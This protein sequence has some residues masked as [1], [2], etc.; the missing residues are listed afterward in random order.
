VATSATLP[1]RGATRAPF[2]LPRDPASLGSTEAP[3]SPLAF[4][5]FIVVNAVLL[6]RPAEIVPS[7]Q[8]LEL[9]F[10]TIAFCGVLAAGDVLRYFSGRSLDTQPITL[11]VAGLFIAV[12]VPHLITFNVVEGWKTGFH[13][14]KQGVYFILL[15]SLVNTPG[16]LR[17]F[18]RCLL[19]ICAVTVVV[20]VLDYHD[21]VKVQNLQTAHETERSNW[22]DYTELERLQFTG[23][24]N[25]PNEVCVWLATLL[26]LALWCL[27]SDRDFLRRALWLALVLL[28][29]YGIFLTRSRGGFL[30]MVA[31]LGVTVWLRYGR[32][33][34]A[35]LA[36]IGLPLLLVLFAGRQTSLDA[37][38][39]TG[40]TRVQLWSDWLD[41][42]RDSPLVGEGMTFK[43]DLPPE[44]IKELRAAGMFMDHVAHNSYLQ[45]FADVG[46][47]GGSLFLGACGVALWSI[48]RVG[49]HRAEGLD[50][51]ARGVQPFL[52]G[53][54][55]AY[56]AG[57]MTL[58]LWTV[59]PTYIV[60]ALAAAYPHLA[61][62]RPALPPVRFDVNLL[63]RFAVAG[64]AFLAMIYLVVRL[65]VNWG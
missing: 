63:G 24:L 55:T 11:C 13:F 8:G 39:G 9:Y 46:F 57:M 65:F 49:R 61:R 3:S 62:G 33:K 7:L 64:V 6:I 37:T 53:A 19:V 45:A 15:V 38:G 29:G 59:T 51:T 2:A 27:L 50:P 4:W 32:E 56:C 5:M 21:L 58:S 44:A 26:P 36:A 34:A 30:A 28:F 35:M 20:A 48:W 18:V 14:F 60:L 40:Q 43:E 25:D 23:I 54:T 31:G 41:R 47:G 12:L 42:F 22:G 16:R 10:Y 1:P 17:T 52:F